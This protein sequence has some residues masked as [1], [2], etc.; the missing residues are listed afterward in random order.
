MG[1]LDKYVQQLLMCEI[2]LESQVKDL[3]NKAREILVEE[4]NVQRVDAPVTGLIHQTIQI[5]GDI[6][7][8]FFDLK[9]LLKVG[10]KCPDTNYLFMGDFVD[11][12]FYSVE[13]FLL[14]LAL[15]VRYPDRITL[16]RGNH[17]SRQITQVYGFYDE[18]LRKYGSVNVWR[19]CCEIFDYMSL[20]AII[21]EKIFCVHGGLSP[22]ITSLDQIRVIDRK[23][24]VPHEGAMCDLLWSDPDDIDGW[25]L[26]PRGAG[27]LFGGDAVNALKGADCSSPSTCYGRL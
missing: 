5:C 16:I 26:S 24:E 11:R 1:D 2:L 8:Q 3:C 27:Y 6:H 10:G 22:S 13:T 23:Q 17:E 7:G 12:G 4:S 19:Y 21:D 25:G 14:L 20:S 15:K 9:E 18:C